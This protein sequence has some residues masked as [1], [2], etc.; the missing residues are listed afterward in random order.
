MGEQGR[1][2]FDGCYHAAAASW[3]EVLP[4][5]HDSDRN[6]Q[7]LENSLRDNKDDLAGHKNFK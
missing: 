7:M 1:T 4:D 3:G 6:T 2:F 5:R